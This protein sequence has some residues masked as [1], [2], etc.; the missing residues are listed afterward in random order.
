[1]PAVDNFKQIRVVSEI[2]TWLQVSEVVAVSSG[3]DR[4]TASAGATATGDGTGSYPGTTG[5]IDHA[6][7]AIDGIGPSFWP[8]IFVPDTDAAAEYLEVN[9]AQPERIEALSILGRATIKQ[10][11]CH[12]LRAIC[13]ETRLLPPGTQASL[14]PICHSFGAYP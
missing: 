9:L 8:D 13:A 7:N 10:P 12:P 4:A 11:V 2:P 5:G 6:D 3:V 14:L 1:M